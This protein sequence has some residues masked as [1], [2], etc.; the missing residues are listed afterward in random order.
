M[1]D[2]LLYVDED[3]GEHAVIEGLRARNIDVLTTIEA[4]RL[5]SNDP[6][7]LEFASSIG[8]SIYTFNVSDFARLHNDYLR[9]NKTHAGI[10]VI[11]DQR[12][13]IGEK[14]RCL[15]SFISR[16]SAEAMVN[17]LEFL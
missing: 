1:S 7:Q 9:Q 4:A 6:S 11:P 10:I 12:Y 5:G 15:A 13:S 3:A 16:T 14:V 17:R 8:R 2:L